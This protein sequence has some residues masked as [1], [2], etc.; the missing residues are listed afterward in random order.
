M[1]NGKDPREARRRGDE[2]GPRLSGGTA[3]RR[4]KAAMPSAWSQALAAA[5]VVTPRSRSSCGQRPWTVRYPCGRAPGGSTR[6]APNAE[7]PEHAFH[8]RRVGLA[9]RGGRVDEMARS[10]AVQRTK[11]ALRFDHGPQRGQH[12]ASVLLLAKAAWPRSWR[13]FTLTFLANRCAAPSPRGAARAGGDA[14]PWGTNPAVCS[15][16]LTPL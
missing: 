7:L 11:D 8:L 1:L 9:A 5:M 14:R 2:R 15:A 12:C 16:F 10:V 13:R 3:N 6:H 4:L